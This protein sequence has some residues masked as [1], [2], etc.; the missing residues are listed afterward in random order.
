MPNIEIA[1]TKGSNVVLNA[2]AIKQ[3][4][5]G[6]RGG[7]LLRGDDGY[8]AARKIYNAMIQHRPAIIARCAGVSDVI[9]GS[10]SPEA[11]ACWSRCAA[12]ATMCR[13]TRSATVG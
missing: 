9:N 10:I 3:F 5:K 8:D 1:T 2:E 7:H 13:A 4:H 12:A 6:L 11:M